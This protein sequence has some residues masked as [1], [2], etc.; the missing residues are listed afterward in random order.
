MGRR[1]QG[2]AHSADPA[3][4]RRQATGGL[5]RQ[6]AGTGAGRG[7][8]K[9]DVLP[10]SDMGGLEPFG[11]V[12]G[13]SQ[14]SFDWDRPHTPG[15]KADRDYTNLLALGELLL[16]YRNEYGLL[17]E[18][19]MLAADE[20]NAAVLQRDKHGPDGGDLGLNGSYLV[21]RQLDQHVLAFWRW[22]AGEAARVGVTTEELAESMVGRRLNGTPLS[23]LTLG[24]SIPG[25]EASEA[26]VND[27]LYD[28]D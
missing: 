6:H 28:T 27:F 5:G 8:S 16:G 9:I 14:P 2:T 22:V 4:K 3:C 12:D 10:T 19:P 13:G 21:F 26:G 23:D 17:T 11:F 25:V 1:Q 20:K 18:R 7:L 24:R 15:T